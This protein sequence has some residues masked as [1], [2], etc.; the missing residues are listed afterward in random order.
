MDAKIEQDVA[1]LKKSDAKT[2]KDV[3]ATKQD[4]AVL[5]RGA[6][7]ARDE[8]RALHE[9]YR[10]EAS[11][12]LSQFKEA[13]AAMRKDIADMETRLINDSRNRERWII[14]TVI[15]AVVAGVAVLGS[16]QSKNGQ[17]PV[18]IYAYPPAVQASAAEARVAPVPAE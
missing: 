13:L 8:G 12:L 10:A 16:L 17:P 1:D 9:V 15:A 2:K 5:Q 14:G 11:K 4:I 7:A 3:A 18:I 6:Q